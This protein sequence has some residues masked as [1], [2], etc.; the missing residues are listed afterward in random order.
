MIFDEEPA[1]LGP[2]KTSVQE[3]ALDD[4]LD[5]K[6]FIPK[7]MYRFD[8][9]LGHHSCRWLKTPNSPGFGKL[10]SLRRRNGMGNGCELCLSR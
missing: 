9:G 4:G 5:L 7:A 3:G 10:S 2:L 6:S 1:W 8:S